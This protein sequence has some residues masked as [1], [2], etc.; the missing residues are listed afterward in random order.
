MGALMSFFYQDTSEE[1]QRAATSQQGCFPLHLLGCAPPEAI[2]C[3]PTTWHVVQDGVHLVLLAG[4]LAAIVL[5]VFSVSA[6]LSSATSAWYHREILTL[7]AIVPNITYL[8]RL[9]GQFDQAIVERESLVQKRRQ[10]LKD[11]YEQLVTNIDDLLGKANESSAALAEN[12]FESKRRDFIRFLDRVEQQGRGAP[13]DPRLAGEFR[14]FVLHWLA[15]FSECSV[16]PISRP[17]LVV[18]K[19]ELQACDSVAETARFVKERLTSTE[20]RFITIQNDQDQKLLRGLKQVGKEGPDAGNDFGPR[21][22]GAAEEVE[23]TTFHRD[24]PSS[25]M[26]ASFAVAPLDQQVFR[27]NCCRCYW[28]FCERVGCRCCYTRDK[29]RGD[30]YPKVNECGMCEILVLSQEHL[31]LMLGFL[32]GAVLLATVWE[33]QEGMQ[34]V[35]FWLSLVCMGVFLLAL[36]VILLNF[37]AI[38]LVQKMEVEVVALQA[39][40]QQLSERKKQ[41]FAFWA[42]VQQLTD[43]WVYR[44]SPRLD[45][46]KEVHSCLGNSRNKTDFLAALN[47]T[48]KRLQIME[49]KLPDLDFWRCEGQISEDSKKVFAKSLS[50]A[51]STSDGQDVGNNLPFI[52][53]GISQLIDEGIPKLTDGEPV[54]RSR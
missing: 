48:N 47:N 25:S 20:V 11:S 18:T 30:S 49:E 12:N 39:E 17:K 27:R 51:I 53:S 8:C 33:H 3:I 43:I 23:M 34:P 32:L 15:V 7:F 37:E 54:A 22:G 50:R 16:D 44:T 4:S 2:A 41:M 38:D 1:A 5:A 40:Q 9:L 6:I 10:E 29:L 35:A 45:L 46:L 19:Q 52:L 13:A 28:C 26:A 42:D 31:F 24:A 21:R 14:E 36:F